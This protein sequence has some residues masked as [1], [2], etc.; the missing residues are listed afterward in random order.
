[1]ASGACADRRAWAD[2]LHHVV[3]ART[4]LPVRGVVATWVVADE[5]AVAD[6]LATA[7]F[8]TE[9]RRLARE[10][11]FAYVRM[12]ADGHAEVSRNFP[13]EVFT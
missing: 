1:M 9:G 13:G 8:F 7:L 12:H 2:G 4:G 5:A 10:F 11:D 3:D 6:G